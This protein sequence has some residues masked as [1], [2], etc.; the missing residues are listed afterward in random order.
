MSRLGKSLKNRFL[1]MA[2]AG[3]MVIT[4]VASSG[5]PVFAEESSDVEVAADAE[6][7]RETKDT[8]EEAA[9][10]EEVKRKDSE[11]VE[12]EEKNG[13][14]AETKSETPAKTETAS[15]VEDA[16]SESD[17]EDVEESQPDAKENKATANTATY[18][19][20]DG[21]S[22]DLVKYNLEGF[23]DSYGVTGGGLLKKGENDNYRIATNEKEFLD[24]ILAARN[25][26]GKPM[27]IEIT[28]DMKL[29]N[30]ELD[31]QS[32]ITFSNYSKF[33][34][35]ET[36]GKTE[37]LLHPTLTASGVSK[38]YLQDTENLTI[39]SKN[40]SSIKHCGIVIKGSKNIVIRNIAFDELW[41]WD[42]HT[43]GAYDRNDWDYL[44]V[45][46]SDGVWID[47]CTF[48]KAYD[49]V[50]DVKF[51]KNTPEGP[52][53]H[54]TI[55]WCRF[56]P[57]SEGDKFFNDMMDYLYK[58]KETMPYYKS[59]LD[60]GFTKEQ[61]WQYAYGQKKTSLLGQDDTLKNAK[62][63]KATYA[64][65]YYLDSMDRMPRLRWGT[66]HE[67]NCVLDAQQLYDWKSDKLLSKKITSNGALSVCEG[68]MLLENC[69]IKG[70]SLPLISG[71]SESDPGWINAVD[72]LYYLGK[73]DKTSELVP[74]NN[75]NDKYLSDHKLTKKPDP[76][77]MNEKEFKDALPYSDYI[78]Y[79]ASKLNDE[80]VPLTGAGSITMSEVQWEKTS[81]GKRDI[82][83]KPSEPEST[84]TPGDKESSDSQNSSEDEST[85]PS[86]PAEDESTQ[87]SSTQ[88]ESNVI[89]SS[90]DSGSETVIKFGLMMGDVGKSLTEDFSK[91]GFT[92]KV[93]GTTLEFDTSGKTI[94]G[95][96]DVEGTNSGGRLKLGNTGS[97][98]NR[99]IHFTAETAG[100]LAVYATSA[101]GDENRPLG[102]FKKDG[103]EVPDSEQIALGS[104]PKAL[105]FKITEPGD[106]YIASKGG[107][108]NLYYIQF[109]NEK[110]EEGGDTGESGSEGYAPEEVNAEWTTFTTP[111]GD[112]VYD[113]KEGTDNKLTKYNQEG[114]AQAANV[115]GGGLLKEDSEYYKKVTNELEFIQALDAIKG[116]TE[117]PHVIEITKDLDLGN[118]YLNET[119]GMNVQANDS[120]YRDVIR[121]FGAN[122]IMHPTLIK[123][124]VSYIKLHNFHN[125]TIFSKN[126]AM[127]KHAGIKIEGGTTNLIFRNLVFDELWEWDEEGNGRYKRNDWDYMTIEDNSEGIWIDHCTFYKAYDGIID[128]KNKGDYNG[129]QR[130]TIS[131]CEILPGSK[132]DVFFNEQMDWLKEHAGETTYYKSLLEE[133]M[134][135]PN[136]NKTMTDKDIW[137]ATHGHDKTHLLGAGDDAPQD[138]AIRMTIA[139]SYYKD[140]RSRLPRLRF[141]KAHEYNCVLDAT[142]LND[143]YRIGNPHITGNGPASTCNG[144]MLIENCY[145]NGVRSPLRSGYGSPTGYIKAVDSIY[146]ID[147]KEG[148]S[149]VYKERPFEVSDIITD[150]G[151]T[152]K[153]TDEVRFRERLQYKDD[154]VKYDAS[155]LYE[156]VVPYAGAGK[157]DLTTV[158]WERT[159]YN[160]EEGG[161]DDESSGAEG[162]DAPE[163]SDTEGSDTPESSET[164][165]SEGTPGRGICIVGLQKSYDYTG[166]KVIPDIEVR[167]YDRDPFI[168]EV[169]APGIDYT[170]KYSNNNKPTTDATITV[171]GKGNYKG[172]SVTEKF[173]IKNV[174][175]AAEGVT[176]A[177]LK[178]AKIDKIPNQEYTG[179]EQHPKF[180]LK[181]KDGEFVE[182]EYDGEKGIYT[183]A[184]AAKTPIPANVAVSNNVNKGTATIL[185]TG[186]QD[187]KS[188]KKTFKITAIDFS[189]AS[190]TELVVKASDAEYAVKG[191]VPETLT[192]TY[193]G[194]L[195]KSGKDYTVK[196]GNNKKAGQQG[197]ITVTG[198]GNYAKKSKV[199]A[200]Y[201]IK[202]LDL[203]KIQIKAV[204]AYD[205]IKAGKVKV[206]VTDENGTALKPAEYDVIRY[207]V[208]ETQGVKS[209]GEP[210][211]DTEVLTA[212]MKSIYVQVKAKDSSL[213]LENATDITKNLEQ[214]EFAVGKNIAKAKITLAKDKDTGKPLT[215]EY[216]GS[217]ITLKDSELIV[218]MK[219]EADPLKPGED[220]QV[221]SYENN[222]NKGTATAVI[223]GN[224]KYSGTKTVKFKIVQKEMVK[225][226]EAIKALN[227]LKELLDG[228]SK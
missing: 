180:K 125:L 93:K 131:W 22:K 139:N 27:V 58:N 39:F 52:E 49:G 157:L 102:L 72:S 209:V 120:D 24:A 40:G 114:Y 59:L 223:K 226:E 98:D 46:D 182:Y 220:Y 177:D 218:T 101:S 207:K 156:V 204:T 206:T 100:K 62:G 213:N 150:A 117:H 63:I 61:I 67:Y 2:L 78:T 197:T 90:E 4:S 80:I 152:A 167:D 28:K 86:S 60:E 159:R 228:L 211:A 14:T 54:V 170:V 68:K 127:I 94:Q 87:S 88:E 50:I 181:L 82:T 69:Y 103:T 216:T 217:R 79:D 146:R 191:A 210:I 36:E 26:K 71:N 89:E 6:S 184:D 118:L 25:A 17:S 45:Q 163:S 133:K 144:E 205:G 185:L 171:T 57:S 123:T 15:K 162:S 195:L 141:G 154:Y 174:Q 198:K 47:H 212:D 165:S 121:A 122:P 176:L 30:K 110:D 160:G 64:N 194:T 5:M 190:E 9:E 202:K 196:Y 151:V 74:K 104:G 189:K 183:T 73:E 3:A 7:Q 116:D 42:E 33:I 188:V 85:Q 84:E 129:Y 134:K 92:I 65:N 107:G 106:Y 75:N 20:T 201:N 137:Y 142:E 224:G 219:D 222:L 145:I 70:I 109:S 43:S 51:D 178:G 115:T 136:V 215:K 143:Q 186:A 83:P 19:T 173:E 77:I 13:G 128:L 113:A 37:P 227:L 148:N 55:S 179:E 12:T 164:T 10:E 34:N 187:T 105:W 166:A 149:Y 8:S 193:K 18:N 48:Y 203:S 130:V 192:V 200:T 168:G 99:S 41:E 225:G 16:E 169:L 96:K 214:A 23:A 1:A 153:V 119:Y 221:V 199:P 32:D 31:A 112:S 95:I 155:K 147:V 161:G 11:E 124:G 44:C 140:A 76:L 138:K 66:A 126:G 108:I 91:N 38:M 208:I 158:Q 53:S 175:N 135:E 56:L 81:Y 97:A 21:D 132:D 35:A 29:G 172:K 111:E